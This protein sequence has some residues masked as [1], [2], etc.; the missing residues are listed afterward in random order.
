MNILSWNVRGLGNPRAFQALRKILQLH[1]AQLVFLCE[2]KVSTMQMNVIASKL[3]FENCLAVN[4]NRRGCGIA[5]LW[6]SDI[7]V[8][9]KSYS[10]YHIDAETQMPNRN[11]M[12]ITGVYGHPEISQKKH[13][14]TLLRR[15][16]V[17]SSSPWLCCGDFN[18][19]L[20]PD[21]KRGGNDRNVNLINEFREVLRD[22]GLKDVGFRGYAF[23]WTNGRYG[24]GFVEERLDRFVCYKAWSDRFVDCAASN[25]D[26][27]TSDHCPV[28]MDM[29][30]SY[31][32][33]KEIIKEE[34]GLYRNWSSENS[35]QSFRQATKTSMGR[36]LG[37]SKREF[38]KRDRK[39]EKLKFQLRE[40]KQR[41]VQFV[42]GEEIRKMEKQIQ[43][44]LMDEEIYWNQRSRADWLKEGD[45]N[46]KIFHGKA[47]ARRKK[48]RIWGI[49]DNFGRWIE[50]PIEVEHEFCNYFTKLFTS[51]QPSQDQ[52]AAALEGITPRVSASM[53]ESLG[54]PFTAEEV[55]EA[56]SQMC[57]TKA[58]GPDGLPAVFYQKHWHTVKEG[59]LT[60]CLH[61]L[62]SQGTIG[63]LNHTY[64]ALI[65][66][67]GKPRK[68]TDFRPISLCNVSYRIVAKTVANRF[69]QVLHKIISPSQSAFIPNRLITDNIIVG[70]ECLHKIRHCKSKRNGLIALKLDVSKAYDRLEWN[71]LE[72]TLEKLGFSQQWISLIM[73]CISSVSFSVLINGAVKG[74]IKPQRGLR[75]GCPLSPYLF[76]TCAEAF[77]SL[78]QQAEQ[79]QLI[80]GLSFGSNLKISHLLFA[81]DSLVFSRASMADCHNLKMIL[82]CYSTTSGQIFNFEKSS[83][84]ISGNV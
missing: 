46:T 40:L 53:N 7:E 83:F 64:I 82:E 38:R 60:T 13:T 37:W 70:Y 68:V 19:I 51:T 63:P 18:E 57:P 62:N 8:Q 43:N 56:L 75:Q 76:I 6:K 14:W 5:M 49:E 29:W 27:W 10:Q 52:I 20:H 74:L 28:L 35:A 59:V 15:L 32:G 1:G 12:R 36:L 81:D 9:I 50:E 21:E 72:Q 30:S 48:N 24:E 67:I 71:F 2:T 58:P 77:S 26:S 22:C 66:K 65:P 84:F 45:K 17:L 16:A 34:W 80:H 47:T 54:A 78:L 61:I 23:T 79:Q 31:D 41:R 44:I 42:D 4:G 25:L 33:C 11:Q 3:S 69:K 73:R 55:L 39:L